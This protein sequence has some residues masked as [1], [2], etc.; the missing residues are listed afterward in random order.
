MGNSHFINPIARVHQEWRQ[1]WSAWNCKKLGPRWPP[2][3]HKSVING[4]ELTW[5][6]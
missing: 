5:D 1:V 3:K 6:I 2:R 4:E